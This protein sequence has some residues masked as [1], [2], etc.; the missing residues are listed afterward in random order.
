MDFLRIRTKHQSKN[1][2]NKR[3]IKWIYQ[4]IRSIVIEMQNAFDRLHS[5]LDMT[6]EI[7]SELEDLS[8]EIS[9][10]NGNKQTNTWGQN[11]Q[12]L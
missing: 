8:I 11:I 1:K 9:K 3:K 6:P 5:N 7:I 4:E 10:T 2:N 12:L